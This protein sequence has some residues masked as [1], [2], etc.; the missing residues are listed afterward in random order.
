ML[1]RVLGWRK[2]CIWVGFDDALLATVANPAAD[3]AS[4]TLVGRERVVCDAV[5]V[6]KVLACPF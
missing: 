5:S 4:V 2:E 6:R 3:E 1:A